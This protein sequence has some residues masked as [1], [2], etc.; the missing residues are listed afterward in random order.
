MATKSAPLREDLLTSLET[1]DSR[2]LWLSSWMI[3]SANNLREKRDGLTTAP[4]VTQTMNLGAFVRLQ[5]F[6]RFL[7]VGLPCPRMPR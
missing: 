6:V 3:H 7:G 4:D 1:L 5:I 2:L